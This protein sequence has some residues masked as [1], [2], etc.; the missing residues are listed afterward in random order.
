MPSAL[1]LLFPKTIRAQGKNPFSVA[2]EKHD[3][4]SKHVFHE[5]FFCPRLHNVA[6]LLFF[7]YFW[8]DLFYFSCMSPEK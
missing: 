6:F 3:E 7:F 5:K 1:L 4:L 8:S 2:K